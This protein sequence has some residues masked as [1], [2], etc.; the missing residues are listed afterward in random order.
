MRNILVL[1][2][3]VPVIALATGGTLAGS[4]TKADPWQVADYEDLKKVGISP[5]TLDGHYRVVADIDASASKTEIIP[6][7]T[8][9]SIRGFK[10][11]ETFSGTFNGAGHVI[12]NLNIVDY[13]VPTTGFFFK[14]DSTARLDSLTLKDYYIMAIYS[15]GIA[16]ENHGVINEVHVDTDTLDFVTSAGG[17]VSVN[18]GTISN[19]SF[20]GKLL[21][22]YLGGIAYDNYGTISNCEHVVK[23]VENP[24][25]AVMYGGIVGNNRGVVSDSKASGE[26][27]ATVNIGGIAS[28]NY[29][30]VQRCS[31]LVDIYGTGGTSNTGLTVKDVAGIGGLVAVDS[32]KIYNSHAVG[33]ITAAANNVGGLVAF[34]FGEIDSCSASGTIK[35]SVYS[36]G[37]VGTNRGK[38]TNSYSTGKIVGSTYLGGFA[39][40][41]FGTIEKSHSDVNVEY[42]GVSGGGF[43]SRNEPEGTIEN[44]YATGNVNGY[45]YAGG[46]AA[47]NGGI[48]KGSHANGLVKGSTSVGGFIGK[49]DSGSV[50]MSYST[51][52]VYGEIYVGGFAGALWKGS[53][54]QNCYSTGDIVEGS[55]HV[56]GFASTLAGATISN[57]FS[58]GN[59]YSTSDNF[60]NAGS[61]V[62]V[63]DSVSRI[64]NSY[65]MG[66]IVN[67]VSNIE[68]LCAM[69]Y[70][71]G[72]EA[73]YWNSDNCTP[74]DT[75][76]YGIALTS[77]QMKSRESFVGFDFNEQWEFLDGLSFP[78]LVGV[79]FDTTLKDTAGFFG[80][81]AER[82]V[83]DYLLPDTTKKDTTKTDTTKVKPDTTKIKPDTTKVNPD[84]AKV[85]QDTTRKDT[86][87]HYVVPEM[88]RLEMPFTCRYA[89][90]MVEMSFALPRPGMADIHIFD[91]QGREVGAVVGL[92]ATAGLREVKWDASPVS[93]GRYIAVL[94]LDGKAIAKTSFSKR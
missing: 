34:T 76:N 70:V 80:R 93:R 44:C 17:I 22:A 62:G 21:G 13:T 40:H 65:S 51:G 2:S 33:N 75:A 11:I 4:G 69:E 83:P 73:Y 28:V 63:A 36:G 5:Y 3:L 46:F 64:E 45:H 89:Q 66:G 82:Y 60:H 50:S 9:V 29:G 18:Y 1:L 23:E 87:R 42:T 37:F 25:T 43:V 92:G 35:T 52:A 14:L 8:T 84:T 71:K 19:S 12:R 16:G 7:T 68:N 85:K 90:G 54:V 86:T 78:T 56:A 24:R 6:E 57:S 48:I 81:D 74:A 59:I 88:A 39:G 58:L 38:I 41:N 27:H 55:L 53:S 72:V 49:Q 26:I 61:F 91:L 20:S 47:E 15:G 32:G 94:R 30:V 31:S 77:E 79:P 67:K 10:P